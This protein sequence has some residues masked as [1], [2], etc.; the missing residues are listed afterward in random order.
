[1]FKRILLVGGMVAAFVLVGCADTI[2]QMPPALDNA[3]NQQVERKIQKVAVKASDSME[4]Y[5][6]PQPDQNEF[7]ILAEH[8][9]KSVL[10]LRNN[11]SDAKLIGENKLR[12]FRLR[13]NAGSLTEA[14]LV[15]ALMILKN[16]PKPIVVHCW[17]GADR[18]GSVIAAGR[19]VFDNWSVEA[20][21]AEMRLSQYG[22]HEWAYG[23]LLKLL[24]SIDWE[25]V[26]MDIGVNS[27]AAD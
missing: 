26:R 14:E 1:M 10:N 27:I 21:I 13:T 4:I 7:K 16:A 23:D 5:R 3:D 9:F 22:Y 20:A 2:S 24:R 12:E 8:G 15:S 25:R 18:T 19:I 6:S 17:H 11:N